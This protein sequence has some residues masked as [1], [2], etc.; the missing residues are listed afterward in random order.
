[1]NNNPTVFSPV[2]NERSKLDKIMFYINSIGI[3]R[4]REKKKISV[5]GQL[6]SL[7]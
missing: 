2:Y 3:F 6:Y 4:E 5:S 7:V 1:M